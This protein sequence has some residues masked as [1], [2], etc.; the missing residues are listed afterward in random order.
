M[1]GDLLKLESEFARKLLDSVKNR[2]IDRR[3][4][5]TSTLMAY[6]QDPRFLDTTESLHMTYATHEEIAG[7]ARDLLKRLYPEEPA[8]QG[9]TTEKETVVESAQP[10]KRQG[11]ENAYK[12]SMCDRL[13]ENKA[14]RSQGKALISVTALL[15]IKKDMDSYEASGKRPDS[16]Q[17]VREIC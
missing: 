11:S 10:P 4:M 7:E 2:I 13:S 5:K 14:K 6:L 16:L 3:N 1:I 17:K 9:P 15:K 12:R 8:N